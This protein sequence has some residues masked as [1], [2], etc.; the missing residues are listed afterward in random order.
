MYQPLVPCASCSRHLRAIEATCP[1]CGAEL[2]APRLAPD[3]VGRMSRAAAFVFGA[4]VAVAGCGNDTVVDGAGAG[5]NAASTTTTTGGNGGGGMGG[6]GGSTTTDVGGGQTLY[7][8]PGGFGGE[9]GAGGA[10]GA[11][12]GGGFSADYGAPP[13]PDP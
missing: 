1:F 13:P 4:T 8:A 9:A 10:G 7:G 12:G 6:T 2:A 3:T 5:G 11:G